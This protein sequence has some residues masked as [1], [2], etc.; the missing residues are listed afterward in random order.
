MGYV[1]PT[2]SMT[3]MPLLYRH[4]REGGNPVDNKIP[5]NELFYRLDS[6]LR[7]ND[8]QGDI[9]GS[10]Y[11]TLNKAATTRGLQTFI[12]H[13]SHLT[14]YCPTL[15]MRHNMLIFISHFGPP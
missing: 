2:P 6:R 5:Y 7:G 4:S 14:F 12:D 13:V 8:E 11:V 10:E 3:S 9:L 15:G 1:G